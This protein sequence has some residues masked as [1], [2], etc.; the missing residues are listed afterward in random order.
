MIKTVS[1][2]Y[3]PIRQIAGCKKVVDNLVIGLQQMNVQ[4]LH[5]QPSHFCGCLHGNVGKFLDKTLPK[6]TLIGP[7]IM[8]LPTEDV[9]PWSVYTHWVQPSEWV[10]DY[11]I[12]FKQTNKNLFYVWPVGINTEQFNETG[13]GNF[14]YDCF[15][16]YKNVTKQTPVE[17]LSKVQKTLQAMNLKQVTLTYGQ[18]PEQQLIEMTKKCKFGIFLTG[19]ESQGLAIMECM[20]SGVPV[21]VV[22]EKNFLY[23]SFTFT[24]NNVSAVPYFDER[25]GMKTSMETFEKDLPVFIQNLQ[26]YKPR[27]YILDNHT[28][29]KGAQKYID[30][31]EKINA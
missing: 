20:S 19:T 1:L 3:T 14:E 13:R 23:G 16:Y 26:K 8:V 30:I 2:Y 18:Y 7:E 15:I 21:L 9:S 25:C 29:V 22:E 31:L 5:N 4:V 6:N 11:M 24:S 12:T 28:L 10:V 27:Q 17:K